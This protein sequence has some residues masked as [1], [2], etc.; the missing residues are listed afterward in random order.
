MPKTTFMFSL[1]FLLFLEVA[2]KLRFN[3]E[4]DGEGLDDLPSAGSEYSSFYF[5]SGGLAKPY[6]EHVLLAWK[7]KKK[8]K[9]AR[10]GIGWIRLGHTK[11]LLLFVL[12]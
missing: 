2:F 3:V 5:A 7:R 8:W 1:S 12:C 4:Q 11:V 9:S 6:Q 10:E